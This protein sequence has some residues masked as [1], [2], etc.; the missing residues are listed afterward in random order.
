MF[1]KSD[2]SKYKTLKIIRKK[3]IG[4]ENKILNEIQNI[5][6]L[7]HEKLLKIEECYYDSINYYGDDK[8]QIIELPIF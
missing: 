6:S 8:I 1:V 2:L 3:I 7:N 5:N 4:D